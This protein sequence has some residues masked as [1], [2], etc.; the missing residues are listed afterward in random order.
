[1]ATFVDKRPYLSAYLCRCTS[2]KV[3]EVPIQP[4]GDFDFCYRRPRRLQ[5]AK[6]PT[7]RDFDARALFKFIVFQ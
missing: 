1:V 3:G 2:R 6:L 7:P 4:N 5:S